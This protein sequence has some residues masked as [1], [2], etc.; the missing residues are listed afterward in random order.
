MNKKE[1]KVVQNVLPGAYG[2]MPRALDVEE[3]VLGAIL[4]ESRT[5]KKYIAHMEPDYF[6]E[7]KN[8]LIFIACMELYKQNDAVDILTV[9]EQLR[10][11]GTLEDA[12]GPYN[13][14]QLSGKVVSSAHIETHILILSQFFMR[15][16]LIEIVMKCTETAMD[17]TIDIDITLV[18]TQQALST[19]AQNLPAINE[20]REMPEILDNVMEELEE[21]RKNGGR[22]LTGIDTGFPS[23]NELL[24]GWNKGT[25]NICGARPGEG[26]TALLVY[27][28]MHAA[29]QGVPTV[30]ISLES[31]AENLTERLLIGKTDIEP[32]DWKK[33]KLDAE[34]LGKVEQAR[35]EMQDLPLRIFDSGYITIEE[36]CVMIKSLH[37]EGKCELVG[38]DY[39]QL[40]NES[41]S[42]GNREQEVAKNSRLLKLLSLNLNI[43]IVL[44]CQLNRE[45]M[46]NDKQIPR[47]ENIRES[48]S[49]EQDGDTVTLLFHPAKAKMVTTPET[50][51]PVTPD[52]LMLIVGKNRNGTP[53]TVYLSHNPSMT[54]FCEYAPDADWLKHLPVSATGGNAAS[55]WRDHDAHYQAFLKQ[56]REKKEMDGKLPF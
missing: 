29:R 2:I 5:A 49:I 6:Y 33:G 55:D 38:I 20:I 39:M 12:G 1:T 27:S 51:Y 24:L 43:P 10:K 19:L 11:D 31:R 8:K 41:K 48:G 44:L 7:P 4:I 21:R 32:Y 50:N 54:Q 46:N 23:L 30:L 14:T 25:L 37:A 3:A 15:R 34:Q 47:L 42:S 40:F 9:T 53:G 56:E 13:I 16:R 18:E 36:A 28:M 26:K 52:M 17:E 45:V 35:R 22:Q